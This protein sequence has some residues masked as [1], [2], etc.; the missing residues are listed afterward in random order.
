MEKTANQNDVVLLFDFW[1]T[2]SQALLAS[3]RK[4]GYDY[5]AVVI[6]DDGFLPDGVMSVYGYFLGNFQEVLG[7]AGKPK[8]F[9]QIPVP[10]YWQISGNNS[11]GQITDLSRQRGKIFYA[12]P[13]HKR[14]VK[15]VDWY[16]ERGVVRCCDHYNRYGA[17]Y[18][19]TS[20][21]AKGQKVNKSYFS[22]TGQ[23]VIVENYV[24][25]DII[26]NEGEEIKFFRTKTDFV[27][28]FFEKTGFSR[29]RVF[30]NS[31]STPFFVSNK[32]TAPEKGD[33]LFWQEPVRDEIPGNMQVILR[34][35][36]SRTA[37]ILVQKRQSYNRLLELGADPDIVGRKGYV[38]SFERKNKHRPEALV[39]TNSDNIEHCREIVEALP[40]MHFHIAA[41]TE[42]S[43][44]LL[45]MDAYG[46]VSLYPGVKT[47][48]LDRLFQGCDYY[49]D[50]NHESEIVSAV[51]RAFLNN[52]LIFAFS[53]TAHNRDYVADAHIYPASEAGRM[54]S[55]VKAV[56]GS[57][58]LA[59]RHL[60]KQREAAMAED[61]EAFQFGE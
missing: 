60:E 4:A 39:C 13:L 3:F 16:D 58:G 5:P 24:T 6:E 57:V 8:Y 20:L 48:I 55:D 51:R 23:E 18:A 56:M 32:L 15:I 31:L 9:N 17:V 34:G 29:N 21:N 14:I 37:R 45:S 47:D 25:G 53:E 28:Y 35:E 44:K 41:L 11:G 10:E 61:I 30:Y 50:I 26:L 7:E 43:S 2:A 40:G 38:Y 59:A 42:M 46:N 49:F 1:G 54:L 52:Q 36:A 22:A 19:R 27:L 12:E 33:V